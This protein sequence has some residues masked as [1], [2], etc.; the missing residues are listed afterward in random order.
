MET[1]PQ[2]AEQR[3]YEYRF[4]DDGFFDRVPAWFKERV[5]QLILPMSDLAR[6]LVARELLDAGFD[7]VIWV[8][9]D[10]LIFDLERFDVDV[11]AN[12]A[13]CRELWLG[14]VAD[15]TMQIYPRVN[16]AVAHYCPE[17]SANK[18]NWLD[19]SGF[20]GLCSIFVT[21]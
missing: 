16:N 13:F 12:C 14:E 9:A 1:V 11:T 8:D 5:R 18:F 20:S 19:I 3:G 7:R 4:F 17:I 6:L 10:V 21:S 2:W 15:G